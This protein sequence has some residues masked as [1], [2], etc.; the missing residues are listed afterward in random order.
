V[1]T[2]WRAFAVVIVSLRFTVPSWGHGD[3]HQQIVLLDSELARHPKN[4]ELLLRRAELWRVDGNWTNALADCERAEV[5]A[6]K[7]A[8]I[9]LVRGR[10]HFDA[11]QPAQATNFLTRF[12]VLH[13]TNAIAW[14]TRARALAA[15]GNGPAAAQDLTRAIELAPEAGPDLFLERARALREAGG[16]YHDE[17]LRGLNEAISRLGPL[18]TLQLAALELEIGL[19]RYDSALSRV[20]QVTE[21]APRKES[22]HVR[23]AEIL[24]QAGRPKE[25]RAAWED[26]LRAVQELPA[27][28]RQTKATVQLEERIRAAL[29]HP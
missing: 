4:G 8:A 10:I 3:V 5:V 9:D 14:V 18:V 25:A 22:W 13:G 28:L 11:G 2:R 6:P 7:L 24:E 1:I 23:R 27:R 29:A 21:G 16:A 19:K 26:A 20:A 17:A 15:L 12:L